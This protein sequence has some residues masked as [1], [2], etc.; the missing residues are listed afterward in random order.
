MVTLLRDPG[1]FTP[2]TP[3]VIKLRP[4]DPASTDNLY[5]LYRN[6]IGKIIRIPKIMPQ[7]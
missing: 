7:T 2:E 4:A 6:S 1:G 5:A 3:E